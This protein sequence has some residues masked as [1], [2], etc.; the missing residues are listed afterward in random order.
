MEEISR[1]TEG[2]KQPST[3]PSCDGMGGL[4]KTGA[5]GKIK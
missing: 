3:Q 2:N 5:A 1:Q 4:T